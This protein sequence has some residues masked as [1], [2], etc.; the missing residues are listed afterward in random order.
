[1]KRILRKRGA[2]ANV[3]RGDSGHE[4]KKLKARAAAVAASVGNHSNNMP[5]V[6]GSESLQSTSGYDDH[7]RQSPVNNHHHD[8]SIDPDT[9]IDPALELHNTSTNNDRENAKQEQESHIEKLIESV[10]EYINNQQQESN[11]S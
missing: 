1:M 6:N 3:S 2:N 5:S 7:Q 8:M 4:D 10:G 9:S 11:H